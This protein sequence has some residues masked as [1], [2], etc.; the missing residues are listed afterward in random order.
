M[1]MVVPQQATQLRE[2][3]IDVKGRARATGKRKT[4]VAQVGAASDGARNLAFAPRGPLGRLADKDFE[5]NLLAAA[6]C[7]EQRSSK[8]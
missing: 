5:F 2:P 6:R 1:R 3:R 7:R 4:S 8:P